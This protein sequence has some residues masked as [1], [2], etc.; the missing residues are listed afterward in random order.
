[1]DAQPLR[2][3][4]FISYATENT[5]FVDWLA[6]KLAAEGYKVWYDRMKLLGGES[7]PR[8]ID[9]AISELSFR[10]LGV[11]S[12]A[13]IPKENPLKERTQALNVGKRLGI[14]FLIPLKIENLTAD[15]LGWQLSDLTYVPFNRSWSQGFGQLVNALD[16]A[17]TPKDVAAGRSRLSDY[18]QLTECVKPVEER[19]W[20]N[21]LPLEDVPKLVHRFR[22]RN[23]AVAA[24]TDKVWP[25]APAGDGSYWAFSQPEE[26][27]GVEATRIGLEIDWRQER[28]TSRDNWPQVVSILIRRAIELDCVRRGLMYNAEDRVLYF[29]GGRLPSDHFKFKGSQGEGRYL[30]V[31]GERSRGRP[32]GTRLVTKYSNAFQ[33]RPSIANYGSPVIRILPTVRTT[34]VDGVPV[35][36]PSTNRARKSVT[37]GWWNYEWLSRVTAY[38]SLLTDGQPRRV[39]QVTPEGSLTLAGELVATTCPLSIDETALESQSEPVVDDEEDDEEQESSQLSTGVE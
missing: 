37:K 14:D 29:Q 23:A 27:L 21:L 36:G 10:V 31:V 16:R 4:L 18:F 20:T 30:Q 6:P 3:H 2:D 22:A 11:I 34:S 32:D 8:D 33:V 24:E 39:L 19:I 9:R 7:Y 38:A 13:S 26:G 12:R 35:K 15:E 5:S 28:R 1:M 25:I 17:G